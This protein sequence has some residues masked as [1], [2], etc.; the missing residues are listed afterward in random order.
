[1]REFN[2][3]LL[4]KWCWRMLVDKSDMWYRYGESVGRVRSG[5]RGVSSWWSEISRLRD[6]TGEGEEKGWFAEGVER[7][8]GDGAEK[9]FWI[10][11]W[12]GGV[13]FC[14]RFRRLYDLSLHRSCRV[15]E[16]SELGWEEGGAA[17]AW[18][19]QL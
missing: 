17:W 7:M 12:L 19:R 10:D 18:R 14:V 4:G 16:M 1:M 5:G 2:S 13:P 3:A 9:L 11:P 8:V 6:G 15:A